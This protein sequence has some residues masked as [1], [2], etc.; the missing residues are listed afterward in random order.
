MKTCTSRLAICVAWA[1]AGPALA[2]EV[3]PK[4]AQPPAPKVE[5]GERWDVVTLYEFYGTKD[6]EPSRRERKQATACLPARQ[7]AP[8]DALSADVPA[9][10]RNKCWQKEK[11]AEE[12][13]AQV[14]YG[15]SDGSSI[16]AVVRR[17][18]AN[19]QGSQLAINIAG[20]GA[21]S[22]TRQMKRVEGAQCNIALP[23]ESNPVIVK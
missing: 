3:D 19:V 2:Q 21:I 7:L 17:E 15:C 8:V 4:I 13:R 22:I 16:E 23:P 10:L 6:R 12:N 5:I 11:R 14:K 1:I 18:S 9:A 20:Q